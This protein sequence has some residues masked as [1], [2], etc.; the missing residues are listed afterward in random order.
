MQRH[1]NVRVCIIGA[2]PSGTTAGKNLLQAG[3]RNF[4]IYEKSD[5]V[6]GNWVF[7]SNTS[8]SSVYETT[9]VISSKTLSQYDDFPM[10]EDYPDY[11]S[12]RQMLAYF[13][14]YAQHFGVCRT[15]AS[16]PR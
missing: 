6:G 7:T 9:H 11:P 15:S 10:P 4:V 2:G 13:Q 8:H 16:T 14:D 1:Q 12:H 3:L 5:Q